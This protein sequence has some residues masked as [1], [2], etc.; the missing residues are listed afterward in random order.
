M[1]INNYNNSL[2]AAQQKAAENTAMSAKAA[3]EDKKLREACK[4]VEAMFMNMMY[5]QMRATVPDNE[6]FG[7]SNADKIFQ[8]MLDTEMV[9]KMADAG[10]FG[11]A[12]VLYRQLKQDFQNQ[13]D[14]SQRAAARNG[15]VLNI[16][17]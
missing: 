5:K 8:D 12:D 11:L 2:M 4:G 1:E 10:G 15:E 17:A 6:L 9:N 7:T 3:K 14:M 16:N 13:Q